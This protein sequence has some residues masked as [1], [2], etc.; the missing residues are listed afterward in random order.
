MSLRSVAVTAP[1]IK[2]KS[3]QLTLQEQQR[4]WGWIFLTPWIIGFLAFSF[5]PMVATVIFSFTDFQIGKP[6]HWIGLANWQKLFTDPITL[7]SITS[8]LHFAAIFVP[9][10]TVFPILLAALLTSKY[11]KGKPLLRVLFFMPYMV[12][13]IS[14]IFIWTGFLNGQSGWL[15][16]LLNIIGIANPPNWLADPHIIYTALTLIG[17]WSV[18][19]AMMTI[20]ISIQNIPAQLHEVASVDGAS[21]TQRFVHITVPMVSPMILYNLIFCV[22]GVMQYFVVPYVT[23]QVNKNATFFDSTINFININL[24]KTMFLNQDMG[25]AATQACFV[26]VVAMALTVALFGTTRRWVYY[27]GRD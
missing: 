8:T 2:T 5:F 26:F 4:I 6:I 19:N 18:G 7:G 13:T 21:A 23:A 16:R 17:L 1:S 12:P 14:G 15:N 11:V 24:Y 27:A 9:I 20:I 10:T 3:R 22:I 25:F